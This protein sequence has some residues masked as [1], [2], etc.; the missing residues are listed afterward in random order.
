MIRSPMRLLLLSAV[1]MSCG[2]GIAVCERDAPRWARGHA[3][4]RANVFVG[5]ACDVPAATAVRAATADALATF[6]GR[7]GTGVVSEIESVQEAGDAGASSHVKATVRLCG[8]PITVRDAEV[9]RRKVSR[10]GSRAAAWVKVAIPR[11]E[12]A[13]L[14]RQARGMTALALTCKTACD[15]GYCPAPCP[16]GF[17]SSV[18]RAAN[19]AGIALTAERLKPGDFDG[20][21]D[22]GAA[23]VLRIELRT[24][25]ESKV[26]DEFYAYGTALM[27]W[28]DSADRKVLAAHDVPETKGGAY[29]R[30]GAMAGAG[31]RA[32][33][34][35]VKALK[36]GVPGIRRSDG[37]ARCTS[38]P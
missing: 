17:V 14:K 30:R 7:L 4:G 31:K 6:A 1:M 9:V 29:S 27:E 3:A 8:V 32:G 38:G 22:A 35:L 12:A 21:T 28:I 24:R 25:F 26:R 13:R 36:N 37:G 10:F 2:G 33:A 18:R 5:E 16:P 11:G 15:Q 34:K 19:R 20:A 23:Y